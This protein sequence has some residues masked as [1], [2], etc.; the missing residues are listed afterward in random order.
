M[1]LR[2]AS[3]NSSVCLSFE[4]FPNACVFRA[5]SF[6]FAL[7]CVALSFVALYCVAVYCVAVSCVA[8]SL[9]VLF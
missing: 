5:G 8:L 9:C 7:S 3:I 2:R 1:K 6:L 4:S